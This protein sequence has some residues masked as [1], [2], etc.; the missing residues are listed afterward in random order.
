MLN[1]SI[2]ELLSII[3]SLVKSDNKADAEFLKDGNV[4]LR[5]EGPI[6]LSLLRRLSSLN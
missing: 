1:T 4:V 3:L 2:Y 6:L 5:C